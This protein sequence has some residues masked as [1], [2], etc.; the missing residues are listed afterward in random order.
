VAVENKIIN[1]QIPNYA[2]NFLSGFAT[3]GFSKMIQL[4]GAR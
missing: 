2:R 1:F 4:H 3:A